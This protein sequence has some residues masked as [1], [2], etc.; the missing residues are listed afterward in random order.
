MVSKKSMFSDLGFGDFYGQLSTKVLDICAKKR[1]ENGGIMKMTDICYDFKKIHKEVITSDDIKRSIKTIEHLGG[2]TIFK[3]EYVCTVP[4]EFSSDISDLMAI[5]E[6]EGYVSY[7]IMK[8][9]KGWTEDRFL[10]KITA[11]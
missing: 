1:S 3:E 2:V 11:L 7:S 10:Q 8:R 9:L 4:V 5:G 6:E